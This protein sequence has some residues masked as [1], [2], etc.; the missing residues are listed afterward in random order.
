MKDVD[1]ITVSTPAKL[2]LGLEILRRRSD[3]YHEIVSILQSIDLEDV[4]AFEPGPPP[5][6]YESDSGIPPTHDLA[7]NVLNS[8]PD[9]KRWAG[10]LTLKKRI[11][12]AAG[13]GGGSSDAALAL[14]LA[15]PR[16]D[17]ATLHDRASKL[18]SDVPFFLQGGTMLA[19]GTGT[20]LTPLPHIGAWY[21]VVTPPLRLRSKTKRLYHG[22]R[23]EDYSDGTK[24][25]QLA[26]EIREGSKSLQLPPN[27][28]ERQMR[29]FH[30]ITEVW[31]D[32]ERLSGEPV[33]L[34]GAGPSLYVRFTDR[35]SA[36]ALYERVRGRHET[37]LCR[38]TGPL[39]IREQALRMA[40]ALRARSFKD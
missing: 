8:A 4:F 24:T 10:R 5:F 7:G 27:A 19:T 37:H 26:T 12:I 6:R 18:G 33:H 16:L 22:L 20:S 23:G 13:L 32:L 25:L 17:E 1:Q 2:N 28:F 21:V 40:R 35:E 30:Q 36:I 15:F 3:G 29:E 14:R 9:R 39:E 38:S 34:S 31:T 11:P